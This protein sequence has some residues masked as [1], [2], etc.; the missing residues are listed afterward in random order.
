[1]PSLISDGVEIVENFLSQSQVVAIN[2]ELDKLFSPSYLSLNGFLGHVFVSKKYQTIALPTASVKSVNLLEIACDASDL[3]ERILPSNGRVLT[4]LEIWQ[5]QGQLEPLFWH[6]DNRDG[7]IRVFI[8]LQGGQVDSGAFRYILGSRDEL[9]TALKHLSEGQILAN[10]YYHNKPS[11]EYISSR[12]D[13]V[14]V[15]TALPGAMVI[16][17]TKGIHSNL[18]RVKRRRILTMEFQLAETVDY[19]R[20]T[21]YLPSSM[22]T[23]KVVANIELFLNCSSSSPHPYGTDQ[24]LTNP[25]TTQ[26]K[27]VSRFLTYFF[28]IL[29]KIQM[30]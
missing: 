29:R 25:P 2:G 22:I 1:M 9:D 17:D 3:I 8:I 30:T 7:A 6:T 28:R 12:A 24:V 16:A 20:S 11:S 14:F 18:P 23:Q 10:K 15:A 5:E 4:A 21:I 26:K 13:S 19:P 27:L